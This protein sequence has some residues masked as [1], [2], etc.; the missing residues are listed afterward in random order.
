MGSSFL[1]RGGP[2][3]PFIGSMESQ[4]VDHQGSLN[5]GLCKESLFFLSG[6]R[7][8]SSR[9]VALELGSGLLRFSCGK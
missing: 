2:Y 7:W 4:S 6:T 1:T 9:V 5:R 3:A 8:L